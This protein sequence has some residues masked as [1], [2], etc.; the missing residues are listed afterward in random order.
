MQYATRTRHV[1]SAD[2]FRRWADATLRAAA[3]VTVRLVGLAE[4][5]TLNREYRGRDYATNVLTFV[6]QDG[7]EY[8]GD[9]ALCAPVVAREAR[10]Q[11]KD[12]IAHYAH[13]TVHG[14]LHLQGY[15]HEC[16]TEAEAMEALE[17]RILKRL[18]FSDP[19]APTAPT[20]HDGRH[21]Q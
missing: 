6:L 9:L 3:V 19:Y 12:V 13:L 21:A 7:P 8:Q 16:E 4:G 11:R 1:P 20:L 18:G 14:L 2:D 5:R 10:E 15:E 17:R